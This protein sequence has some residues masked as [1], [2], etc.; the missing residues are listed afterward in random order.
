MPMNKMLDLHAELKALQE[1]VNR[2]LRSEQATEEEV[3]S[4]RRE[5]DSQKRNYYE[6]FD[7]LLDEFLETQK[8]SPPV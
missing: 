5:F 1:E 4:A 7:S 6:K 3:M 8:A 2:I